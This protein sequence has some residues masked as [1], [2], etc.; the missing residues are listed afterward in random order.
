MRKGFVIFL[1]LS[2]LFC[3]CHH[4]T[5]NDNRSE[6]SKM[7][8]STHI[9]DITESSAEEFQTEIDS[10]SDE[11]TNNESHE[12]ISSDP[13]YDAV[14]HGDKVHLCCFRV[15]ASN[16]T[17]KPE[18]LGGAVLKVDEADL[19]FTESGIECPESIVA[20]LAKEVLGKTRYFSEITCS[21]GQYEYRFHINMVNMTVEPSF[22]LPKN[23]NYQFGAPQIGSFKGYDGESAGAID[24]DDGNIFGYDE[25]LTQ[26]CSSWCG[27]Q[28]YLCEVNASSVLADQGK[29]S[30]KASHL[31][32][33]NRENVWSEGV[34]GVGIGESI[35]IKQMYM[36][37]GEAELSFYSICIV[38][39]YAE[40][41]T[42]WKENG[43]VKSLK[44]YFEGE[45]MGLITLE[46]TMNPQYIDISAVQMR[47]GN[48]FDANFKFE[49]A[50][51]YEGSKYDDTCLTGIVIDFNGIYA[52]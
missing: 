36:G 2:L 24:L 23:W 4:E 17:A 5:P 29:V 11:E 43:R 27:C 39:G 46:D 33:G 49:I 21:D 32:E 35:E 1:T 18:Y 9:N 3:S 13:L 22:N 16:P 52:H 8:E 37:S 15:P 41:E 19:Q 48:G 14:E 10:E 6:G 31:A 51:V 25:R 45:Y 30:Y 44:L 42:K 47:V 40:N 38:N 20:D 34:E 7:L 26:G 28:I 12:E 50:D